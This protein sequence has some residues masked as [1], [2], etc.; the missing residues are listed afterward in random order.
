MT[1]Y[2]HSTFLQV[3]VPMQPVCL[4]S[5]LTKED[6]GGRD[7]ASSAERTSMWDSGWPCH[8]EASGCDAEQRSRA[9]DAKLT[10][11]KKKKKKIYVMLWGWG[12]AAYRYML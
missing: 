9:A 2:G 6:S 11:G 3:G 1:A 4:S 7:E 5:L 12:V 10:S 8:W